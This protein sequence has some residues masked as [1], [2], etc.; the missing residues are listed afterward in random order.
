MKKWNIGE[1][2]WWLL[3]GSLIVI[4]GKIL[5]FDELKFYL[6]PKMNWLV[7]A[8][9]IV[10]IILFV[11]QQSR[12]FSNSSKKMKWGY[13][14]FLIPMFMVVLAGDAGAVIFENR[15]INF[16]GITQT[17]KNREIVK[18][19]AVEANVAVNTEEE[20]SEESVY[21]RLP[22]DQIDNPDPD[23]TDP[24]DPAA[25][26]IPAEQP[27]VLEEDS[28]LTTLYNLD[29]TEGQE[30]E[31]VGFVFKNEYFKENQFHISRMLLN[32]CVADAFIEGM[33]VQAPIAKELDNNEWVRVKG[34]TKFEKL[35][36]PLTEE[37]KVVLTIEAKE[38]EKVEPLETPYVFF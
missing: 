15:N 36:N 6:H 21:D 26:H 14:V 23:A 33:V 4:I 7:I 13:F 2:C 34:V 3:I 22:A 1:L 16:N 28:F 27:L 30:I 31:L 35:I 37:E 18:E 29:E 38:V 17:S 25:Q 20:K 19:A 5:I 9:E 10:L 8:A 12:I 24:T 32:C 11:Y